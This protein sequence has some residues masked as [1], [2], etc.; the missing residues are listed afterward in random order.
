M[1]VVMGIR[2]SALNIT[3]LSAGVAGL[4]GG[5]MVVIRPH[6]VAALGLAA[7]YVVMRRGLRSA[8]RFPE[9]YAA[10]L[11]CIV[12]LG[13]VLFFFPG[14][15][16]DAMPMALAVYVPDKVDYRVLFAT[17]TSVIWIT[18]ALLA[19]AYRKLIRASPFASVAAL[20]SAGGFLSYVVQQKGLPYHGYVALALIFVTLALVFP[21]PS[22]GSSAKPLLLIAVGCCIALSAEWA[23]RIW[24]DA[25]V[26]M[27]LGCAVCALV[28]FSVS[29]LPDSISFKH[30]P[31][32]VV[33]F[34]VPCVAF[35][36]ATAW[37]QWRWRRDPPFLVEAKKLGHPKLALVS[38]NPAFVEFLADRVG[39]RWR[40]HVYALGISHDVDLILGRD[41]VDQAT[42]QKLEAYRRR[43][44]DLLLWDVAHEK[45][46]AIIVDPRWAK[47]HLPRSTFEGILRNYHLVSTTE[48][49]A[50][51]NRRILQFYVRDGPGM[52]NPDLPLSDSSD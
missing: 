1:L 4:G 10:C 35:G 2:A 25:T 12:Y 40:Q 7:V 18:L 3:A 9:F 30:A 36:Q 49:Q 37:H 6:Y 32:S 16:S 48:T 50:S 38:E 51:E 26:W 11:V 45:P 27:L 14:F 46:D 22:R 29:F 21:K 43:E 8:A 19:I 24:S 5:L 20:A 39:A 47:E 23:P 17:A 34:L 33:L 41:S 31:W 52:S 15:V 13:V 42:R 28:A 44:Q